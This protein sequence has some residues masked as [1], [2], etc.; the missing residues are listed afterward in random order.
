MTK[1]TNQNDLDALSPAECQQKITEFLICPVCGYI[2]SSAEGDGFRFLEDITVFRPV[3]AVRDGLV[4]IQ[5]AYASGEGYDDGTAW[6][7]E[8]RR[9][10]PHFCGHEWPVPAWLHE[11][12]DWVD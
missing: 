11:Y 4:K 2:G 9:R 3:V 8:C 10:V 5:G 12:M 6:R 1:I 7:F